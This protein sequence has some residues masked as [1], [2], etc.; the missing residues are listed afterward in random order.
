MKK[1]IL[2]PAVALAFTG[3]VASPVAAAESPSSAQS[4]STKADQQKQDEADQAKKDEAKKAAEK[5]EAEKKAKEEKKEKTKV[6][7]LTWG[8]T[9]G[10]IIRCIAARAQARIDRSPRIEAADEGWQGRPLR[11]YLRW[12]LALYDT[13]FRH[14]PRTQN[15]WV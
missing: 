6:R 2:A 15:V 4:A 10:L 5:A 13:C 8:S 9:R 7:R 3:L 12:F 11:V 14:S 1:I